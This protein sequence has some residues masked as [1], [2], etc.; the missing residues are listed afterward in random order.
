MVKKKKGQRSATYSERWRTS[1]SLPLDVGAT[2][3]AGLGLGNVRDPEEMDGGAQIPA[4]EAQKKQV[5]LFY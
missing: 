2:A 4:T 5:R 3:L 1:T